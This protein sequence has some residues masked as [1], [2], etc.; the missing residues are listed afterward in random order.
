MATSMTTKNQARD[1]AR[2]RTPR[3]AVLAG[4]ALALS[5]V[6][7]AGMTS[8]STA[9]KAP[10]GIYDA[11]NEAARLI[12]LGAKAL[13]EASARS[14]AGFYAEAYRIYT[15]V[16]DAEGRVRALDGLGRLA[17]PDAAETKELLWERAGRIAAES[18]N[19][20]IIA[21]ASLLSAELMLQQVAPQDGAEGAPKEGAQEA[22]RLA[23]AAAVAFAKRTADKARALR[24]AASAAKALGDYPGALRRLE[25]AAGIDKKAR[26]FIEYASDRYIAASVHSKSGDYASAEAALRD[27]LDSDRRAEHAAGIGGDYLAL[28][29]VA[30]K[31]GMKEEA[32][33]F[34]M[35]AAETYSAARM[36]TEAAKADTRREALLTR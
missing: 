5:A 20:Q 13:R 24:I 31:A 11:R 34:Y 3:R 23:D 12:Q 10:P 26:A 1:R 4:L 35:R 16:D 18:G 17:V 6:L 7:G 27:A 21:V 2:R 32:L 15:A 25:E 29:I 22:L 33:V 9:P 8:C 28:A 19:V 36:E 30:E 14:A